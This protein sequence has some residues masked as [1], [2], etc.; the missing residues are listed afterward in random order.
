MLSRKQPFQ[1]QKIDFNIEMGRYVCQNKSEIMLVGQS[2]YEA[3]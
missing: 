2:Q 3:G 1:Q